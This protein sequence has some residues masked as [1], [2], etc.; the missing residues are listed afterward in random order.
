MPGIFISY[1]REDQTIVDRLVGDLRTHGAQVWL[2]RTAIKPGE[3]WADA[4][5][6]GRK[7]G[8][9][10]G[11]GGPLTQVALL[12]LIALRFPGQTL[13]WDDQKMRFTNND[14]ANAYINPAY[15]A[16]WKL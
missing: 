2:D 10:F 13:K 14:A 5:R 9:N 8:S 4:I 1:V 12:G 6:N 3:R 11:Y 16:G 15:R 7:A